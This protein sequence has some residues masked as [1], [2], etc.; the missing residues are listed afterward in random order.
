MSLVDTS[1]IALKIE[2]SCKELN[3]PSAVFHV[4]DCNIL[5]KNQDNESDQMETCETLLATN[6]SNQEKTNTRESGKN[7]GKQKSGKIVPSAN[8]AKLK[9]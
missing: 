8:V 7:K 9:V 4:K 1:E 3:S 6:K 5:L 2:R